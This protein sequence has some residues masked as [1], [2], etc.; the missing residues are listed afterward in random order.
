M[1]SI[2]ILHASD[3]H[4]ARKEGIKSLIEPRSARQVLKSIK[5]RALATSYDASILQSFADFVRAQRSLDAILLTGDIATTGSY[6]DLIAAHRFV[7]G[8]TTPW[9]SGSFRIFSEP[10]LAGSEVPLWLL[11]GNHDRFIPNKLVGFAPGSREFHDVFQGM[12]DNDVRTYQTIS[13]GDCS[14]TI[15]GADL[16]LR[17]LRDCGFKP[18]NMYAQ[19]SARPDIVESLEEATA[20]ARKAS[21]SRNTLVLWAIHFPP[22]YP[23]LSPRMKLLQSD[24]IIAAANRS[25]VR[26]VLTGHTHDGLE[27][28]KPM[29]DFDVLCAGTASEFLSKHGNHFQIL[30]IQNGKLRVEHYKFNR[31]H[32]GFQHA[33]TTA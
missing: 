14:V 21:D 24:A 10:S 33:Y 18:W 12:W 31:E 4:I 3:L 23:G 6:E 2:R 20:Q 11:P 9:F 32:A 1:D 13:R 17:N 15:I 28:R 8:T 7:R 16:S 19:G 30:N 25:G 29:M 26:A 5:D 22:K 27:Y